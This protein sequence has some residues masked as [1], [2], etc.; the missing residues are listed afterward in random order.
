[1]SIRTETSRV[2]YLGNGSTSI[3]YAIPFY[4]F[5][6]TDLRVIVTDSDSIDTTLS[7]ETDFKVSGEGKVEGGSIT[8]ATPWYSTHKITIYREVSATQTTVYEENAEFPAKSHERALDKLTMLVQQIARRVNQAFSLRTSDGPTPEAAKV[9]NSL[10]GL[11]A[12]GV[13]LFRTADQTASWLN[14]NQ[15]FFDRPTKTFLNTA[16]RMLAIPEFTGQLAS[17]RDDGSLWISTGITP[18]EWAHHVP[19]EGDISLGMLSNAILEN[20]ASGRAKMADG[21]LSSNA[22]GRAKMDDS[23]ITL[24]KIGPGTFT[25]DS[26]GREKFASGF[27]DSN[28]LTTEAIINNLPS[29]AVIQSQSSSF[30]TYTS[31]TSIIV[32]NDS[33]P[34]STQG[35]LLLVCTITPKFLSSKIRIRFNG[36]YGT[37]DST[38]SVSTAVFA[39]SESE[40]FSTSSWFFGNS[41]HLCTQYLETEHSPLSLSPQTYSIRIGATSG[42]IRI[43]GNSSSRV[44]GGTAHS[45]L[46]LEEIKS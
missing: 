4:F 20:S 19:G 2:Q 38:P 9:P 31:T 40:A 32:T 45:Y 6:K 13:P 12:D 25:A 22:E 3:A 10:L 27:V 33:K 28:L 42:V 39:N 7:L 44:F 36:Y 34:L 29:G 30:N 26:A 16:E 24:P 41:G 37:P 8:T 21:Y 5:N 1:M 35:M 43:N 18:G 23:F 17:Q 15:Q 11:G 14:L 46:V